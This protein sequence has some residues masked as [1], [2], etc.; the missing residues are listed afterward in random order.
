MRGIALVVLAVLGVS[1]CAQPVW[2]HPTK[3]EAAFTADK[4]ECTYEATKAT[5]Y[6]TPDMYAAFNQ[7]K[8]KNEIF[9]LCMQNKGYHLGSP[10][11]ST[12][13]LTGCW[14]TLKDGTRVE[15]VCPKK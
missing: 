1:G 5:A 10:E 9:T 11:R 12:R 2:L 3:D 8:Q 14:N 15:A 6:H 4:N 7:T 13:S